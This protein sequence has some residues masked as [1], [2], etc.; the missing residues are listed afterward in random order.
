MRSDVALKQP[1]PRE[2]LPTNLAAAA[3]T[4]SPDVHREGRH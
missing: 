2:S 1:G 3:L 4:V